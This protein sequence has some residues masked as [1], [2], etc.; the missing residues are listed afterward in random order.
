MTSSDHNN[1]IT[2]VGKNVR[3]AASPEFQTVLDGLARTEDVRFTPDGQRIAIAGFARNTILILELCPPPALEIVGSLEL[4]HA[5]INEPHGLDWLDTNRLAVAN[6]QGAV[7]VLGIPSARRGCHIADAEELTCVAKVN[8]WHEIK[9]PGSVAIERHSGH[10]GMWVCNNYAH[11]VSYHR[12][13]D[14]C[15]RVSVARNQIAIAK[16]LAVPDGVSISNDG[17]FMAIS[18]H[19]THQVFMY[20]ITKPGRA[21]RIGQ[22]EHIDFPHGLR[23]L[24]GGHTLI[25]ADAGQPFLHVF[26]TKNGWEGDHRPIRH[27]RVLDDAT[28]LEGRYNI[29]EGGTKGIDVDNARGIVATTCELQTL[30]LFHLKDVIGSV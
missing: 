17:A 21:K 4:H 14:K 16:D 15:G 22:L 9:S 23:F 27:V 29:Q 1:V 28:Y 6:R 13:K 11:R 19:D 30:Q 7:Q 10:L 12:L 5:G 25:V 20:A 8:P 18:N 3:F 26:Q 2:L 24:P